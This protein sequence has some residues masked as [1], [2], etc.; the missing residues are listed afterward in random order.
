MEYEARIM[1]LHPLELIAHDVLSFL[2]RT[3]LVVGLL[4]VIYCAYWQFH[5]ARGAY[6]QSGESK[7]QITE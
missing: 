2:V 6:S 7:Q 5:P 1:F 3:G 4:W